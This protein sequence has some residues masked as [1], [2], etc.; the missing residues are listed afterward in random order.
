MTSHGIVMKLTVIIIKNSNQE[1]GNVSEE[2]ISDP[3]V[4]DNVLF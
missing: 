1:I 2:D 3:K 4:H